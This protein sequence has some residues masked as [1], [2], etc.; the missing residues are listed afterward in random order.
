M[1]RLLLF[2]VARIFCDAC[3][4]F[5]YEI[6]TTHTETEESSVHS[7]NLCIVNPLTLTVVRWVQL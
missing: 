3:T 2:N 7:V 5:Y 6:Q 1:K 4:V